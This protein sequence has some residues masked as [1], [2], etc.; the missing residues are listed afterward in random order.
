MIA[1]VTGGSG[2]GKS[3]IAENLALN[4]EPEK[5]LYLATM[6]IWD[7][8]GMARVRRHRQMREGKKFETE[9]AFFDLEDFSLPEDFQRGEA[10]VLL[11]CM[12]NLVCNEFYRKEEEVAERLMRGI[13]HLSSQCRNLIAVTNEISS[14]GW[15]YGDE[16]ERYR[17][18]LGE[19][20]C[21]L[22][23]RAEL[24]VEAVYGI[25]VV[26]KGVL[27]PI[28]IQGKEKIDGREQKAE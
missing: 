22:A 19:V 5:K 24:V 21:F 4:L 6:M 16:T 25:P 23:S 8:E 3:E 27:K 15:F 17:K 7:E 9:E 18:I 12:S 28:M 14:D 20:N 1:V 26:L 13:D 10:T 2:S 11:E